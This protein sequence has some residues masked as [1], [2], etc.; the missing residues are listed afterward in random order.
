MSRNYFLSSFIISFILTPLLI[1]YLPRASFLLSVYPLIIF[2]VTYSISL[3]LIAA[4]HHISHFCFF[5]LLHLFLIINFPFFTL[6]FHS[7]IF[8]SS[9]PLLFVIL[10]QF[11][12]LS[13]YF[14]PFPFL[15]YLFNLDSLTFISLLS[16]LPFFIFYFLCLLVCFLT[17]SSWFFL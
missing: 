1:I 2:L 7:F 3:C 5:F 10:F 4:C 16:S 9:F 15:V 11:Y 17:F 12:F 13:L 8:V 6:A 14:F